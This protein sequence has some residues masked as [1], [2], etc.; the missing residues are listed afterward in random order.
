VGPDDALRGEFELPVSGG[1]VTGAPEI[2]ESP[3]VDVS[4]D[5]PLEIEG[6]EGEDPA[7]AFRRT[8]GMFATGVTIITTQSGEQ[9]H[10]MTANAFMSVSLRP[11]LVVISV[12]KRAKMNTLLREGVKFG[13]NVLSEDQRELSDHFAGRPGDQSQEARFTLIHDTPLVDGALAHLVAR[14]ERSYWG[15]DHS[16]FLGRVEYARY[17]SGTPLLFHGGQYEQLL[18]KAAVFSTLS[19]EI[20]EPILASGI[21][22]TFPAGET[23]VHQGELG[24]LLY[25]ILEGRVRVERDGRMLEWLGEGE[26]FGEVAVFD[27]RPRSADIIAETYVRSLMLSR[28]VVREALEREPRAAWA[29]L[30]V[31]ASRLR[32]D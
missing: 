26:F 9:V 27:G 8:L 15:G 32:G 1:A 30:Q 12:D 21:E 13:V 5:E 19:P 16:L 17:G 7:F 24:D 18:E 20:L 22:R 23:I 14:A 10:G 28:D 31:L 11:P 3:F 6:E 25:V 2:A 4:G 29:M